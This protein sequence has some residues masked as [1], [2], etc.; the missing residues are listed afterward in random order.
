MVATILVLFVRT[1]IPIWS[2]YK[3]W[4]SVHSFHTTLYTAGVTFMYGT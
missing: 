1:K 4:A 3:P 2:F